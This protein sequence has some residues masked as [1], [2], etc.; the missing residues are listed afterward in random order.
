MVADKNVWQ[1]VGSSAALGK[2]G[3]YQCVSVYVHITLRAS[4]T[5]VS[6]TEG[7]SHVQPKWFH[8]NGHF[9]VWCL[10]L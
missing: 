6:T 2:F 4:K 7:S 1:G 3:R 8:M 10:S 5:S 9:S